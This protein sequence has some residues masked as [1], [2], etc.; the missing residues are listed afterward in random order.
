ML[1]PAQSDK[2]L[3]N[4]KLDSKANDKEIDKENVMGG[5]E[6]HQ[7]QSK[8]VTQKPIDDF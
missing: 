8:S 7:G 6:V 2:A 3:N 1:T 5:P 4:S